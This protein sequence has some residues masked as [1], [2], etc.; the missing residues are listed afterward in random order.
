MSFLPVGQT[1]V[2]QVGQK[3]IRYWNV[4][5]EKW[6]TYNINITEYPSGFSTKI[7]P[8]A[9][10]SDRFCFWRILL[11]QNSLRRNLFHKNATLKKKRTCQRHKA[12]NSAGHPRKFQLFI[13]ILTDLCQEKRFYWHKSSRPVWLWQRRACIFSIKGETPYIYKYIYIY[14]Y[15]YIYIC[16]C[17]VY[18]Y[19]VYIVYTYICIYIYVYIYSNIHIYKYIC[20]CIC[21]YIYIYICMYMFIYN[22]TSTNTYFKFTLRDQCW[23]LIDTK[24]TNLSRVP[25][26]Q[27]RTQLACCFK[28]RRSNLVSVKT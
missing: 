15:I 7:W 5:Y 18:I 3:E 19:Y 23:V 20:I 4:N 9:H 27:L 17:V 25:V 21:I 1:T 13:S 11:M 24:S 12:K 8:A 6:I 26:A 10:F 14:T 16:V 2:L 28:V 22:S